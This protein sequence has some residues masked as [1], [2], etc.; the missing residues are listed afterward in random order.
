MRMRTRIGG[1]LLGLALLLSFPVSADEGEYQEEGRASRWGAV[2]L[3]VILIR[4]VS[5][6]QTLAG[7]AFFVFIAKDEPSLHLSANTFEGCSGQHPLRRAALPDI[8][9]DSGIGI[10]RVDHTRDV[11]I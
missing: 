6:G 1:G 10:G 8:E 11:S 2:A 7:S 9:V 4:P 5:F 3:D